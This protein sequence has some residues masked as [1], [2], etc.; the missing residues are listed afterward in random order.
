MRRAIN[1]FRI[2]RHEQVLSRRAAGDANQKD[3]GESDGDAKTRGVLVSD[4]LAGYVPGRFARTIAIHLPRVLPFSR[5]RRSWHR[6]ARLQR[7][8]QGPARTARAGGPRH[9]YRVL[10]AL[11][12]GQAKARRSSSPR[13]PRSCCGLRQDAAL[14][15]Y[16][17]S[18]GLV[19]AAVV[20]V[21]VVTPRRSGVLLRSWDGS[22]GSIA[23]QWALAPRPLTGREILERP[24][25]G[26]RAKT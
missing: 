15:Y 6:H 14:A 11:A 23:A 2:S 18:G 4:D 16:R 19:G 21:L 1:G 10:E 3:R 25:P 20:L 22:S 9:G 24:A 8:W 7:C 13:P 5:G 26:R 17:P 12:P